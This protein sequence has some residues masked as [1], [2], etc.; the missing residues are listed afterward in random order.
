MHLSWVATTI[1][2]EDLLH[3]YTMRRLLTL[4]ILFLL[5]A[6]VCSGAPSAHADSSA[7]PA[8][9]G[10]DPTPTGKQYDKRLPP[11]LPG[12]EIV[13]E[14]G[15]KMRVW[16]SSGPVPVNPPQ[17]PQQFY[18]GA[19]GVILDGRGYPPPPPPPPQQFPHLRR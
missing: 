10:A 5:S 15:R 13:T 19:P 17:Q 14:G 7:G 1:G 9:Q 4:P 6:L 12:E 8:V 11:V 18:G 16:S 3:G 2:T